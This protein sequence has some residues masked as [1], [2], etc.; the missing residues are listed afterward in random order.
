ML[1]VSGSGEMIVGNNNKSE[2]MFEYKKWKARPD[3]WCDFEI[4]Q[5]FF[6]SYM[7]EVVGYN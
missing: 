2:G 6:L 1:S 7:K 5:N 3:V 4:W